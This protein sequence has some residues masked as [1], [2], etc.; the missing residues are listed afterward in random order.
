MEKKP[1]FAL[2]KKGIEEKAVA[3]ADVSAHL[4]DGW[5]VVGMAEVDAD[6]KIVAETG[7]IIETPA[8]TIETADHF[9]K[10]IPKFEDLPP[11]PI[12]PEVI[13]PVAKVPEAKFPEAKVL[14]VKPEEKIKK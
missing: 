4:L 1:E 10:A 8:H 3:P 5:N 11:E 6:G 13:A 2:M 14:E 7:R 9:L 12:V